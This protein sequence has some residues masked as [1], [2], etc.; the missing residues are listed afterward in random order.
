MTHKAKSDLLSEDEA[1][2]EAKSQDSRIK[3]GKVKRRSQ[4]SEMSHRTKPRSQ[5]SSKQRLPKD[6]SSR[7][8]KKRNM[9]G[10]GHTQTEIQK[11]ENQRSP[12]ATTLHGRNTSCR[13]KR[14]LFP[15]GTL[16]GCRGNHVAQQEY[17][18]QGQE[19]CSKDGTPAGSRGNHNPSARKHVGSRATLL[20]RPRET[21]CKMQCLRGPGATTSQGKYSKI[22]H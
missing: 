17:F 19:T 1:Q 8:C 13:A 20:A 16:A 2:A 3:C 9:W 6:G 12:G 18:L 4:V 22:K 11:M 7:A 10:K 5:D 14:N 15:H 21:S